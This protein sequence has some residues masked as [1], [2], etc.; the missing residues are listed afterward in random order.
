MYKAN[1]C[2]KLSA[3]AVGS[4]PKLII[5]YIATNIIIIAIW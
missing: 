5:E 1:L 2:L 4:T 3:E